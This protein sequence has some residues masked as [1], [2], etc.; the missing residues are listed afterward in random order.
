MIDEA[1]PLTEE[2][3]AEKEKLLEEVSGYLSQ[4]KNGENV[5]HI[6]TEL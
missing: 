6:I 4:C 2:E 3:I 5:K 1:E